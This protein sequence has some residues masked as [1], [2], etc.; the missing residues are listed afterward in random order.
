MIMLHLIITGIIYEISLKHLIFIDILHKLRECPP[1]GSI[2][3][4]ARVYIPPENSVL[5]A[6]VTVITIKTDSSIIKE[7]TL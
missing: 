4:S 6:N 3:L 2:S 5:T 1:E 7:D